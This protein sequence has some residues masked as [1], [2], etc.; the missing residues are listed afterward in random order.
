MQGLV[1]G[2]ELAER[3]VLIRQLGK[4]GM[5]EIWLAEDSQLQERVAL[6]VLDTALSKSAGFVD[7]LQQECRKARG[8]V[9]PNIVRVYDFHPD[10]Q[11]FFISMQYIDGETLVQ[12]RGKPFRTITHQVLMVCDALEYA[13]RAGIIHRDLKSSNVLCDRNGVCYLTDFGIAA[14]LTDNGTSGDPRSGHG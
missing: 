4:G 13:H 12:T 1:A 9:H 7:L 14:V 3:F 6:K 11:R 10:D 5:G 8:L 2:L